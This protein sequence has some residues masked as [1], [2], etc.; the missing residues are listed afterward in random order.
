MKGPKKKPA[1]LEILHG[2]PGKRPIND[3][4]LTVP[5]E[6]PPCPKDLD[7]TAKKEWERVTPQLYRLGMIADID[8]AV[9]AG[10][11]HSFSQFVESAKKL[12][13]TGFLVKAPSGYPIVNP[14]LSINNEAKR[15]M[16]K[17]AQEL[18]LSIIQRS[19]IKI[20]GSGKE[21]DEFEKFL[22]KK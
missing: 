16:L 11:C 3:W 4:E 18:G 15:Q 9:L 10:Y 2:Q 5:I 8:L 19:R 21:E 7:E 22:G 17:Y 13:A 20:T 12:K 14:L 6:I 1:K